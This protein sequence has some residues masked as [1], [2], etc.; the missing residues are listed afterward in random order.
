M[1]TL[2]KATTFIVLSVVSLATV[3]SAAAPVFADPVTGNQN[4]NTT[5]VGNDTPV[6][7]Q[8]KND[9][10]TRQAA[11][12]TKIT[13]MQTDFSGRISSIENRQQ[14]NDPKVEAA[15]VKAQ[16]D[17]DAKIQALLGRSGL[18]DAQKTA[19]TTFQSSVKQAEKTREDAVDAARTTYRN[20]LMEAVGTHQNNLVA[21]ANTF[22][23]AVANSFN[24]A[25]TTGCD[26]ATMATLRNQV[27]EARTTFA[28]SRSADKV[29]AEIKTLM[30]VRN[31]AIKDANTA[32]S[33]AVSG[34]AATLK[35]SL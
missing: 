24:E 32:F 8:I 4:G 33:K 10:S 34:Y 1:K 14:T 25:E 2:S 17:F 29:T 9:D 30:Q 11:V 6:C 12:A 26:D 7:K 27:R 13:A 16:T 15:R 28:A 5:T 22:K 23:Q 19:I 18:T 35:Q 3:L 31:Q 21:A 20:A